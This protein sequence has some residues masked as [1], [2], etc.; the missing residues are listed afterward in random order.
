M[1]E[2]TKTFLLYEVHYKSTEKTQLV[3]NKQEWSEFEWKCILGR[4]L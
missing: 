4:N 1:E 3:E 2:C